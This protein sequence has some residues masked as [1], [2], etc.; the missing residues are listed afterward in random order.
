MFE[1]LFCIFG[2]KFNNSGNLIWN[3]DYSADNVDA[4]THTEGRVNFSSK[5]ND[6][7]VIFSSDSTYYAQGGS[8]YRELELNS[9][10]QII[11]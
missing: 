5:S 11:S 8:Y 1:Y 2:F 7:K 3:K 10:G 4:N 9:D 6:L